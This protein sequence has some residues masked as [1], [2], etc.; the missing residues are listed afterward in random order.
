MALQE[1]AYGVPYDVHSFDSKFYNFNYE[2]LRKAKS[3]ADCLH[4]HAGSMLQNDEIIVY[5][6][7]QTTI[8]YLIEI[9][10]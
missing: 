4:A 3:N 6:Q 8:K 10:N 1:V 5:N 9:G 2:A 7:A